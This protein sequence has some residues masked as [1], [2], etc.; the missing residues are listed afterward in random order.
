MGSVD[1][2]L[3]ANGGLFKLLGLMTSILKLDAVSSN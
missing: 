3:D 2:L 1:N